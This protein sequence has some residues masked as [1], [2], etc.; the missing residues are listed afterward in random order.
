M[1]CVSF[2]SGRVVGTA[3]KLRQLSCVS[4]VSALLLLS[5]PASSGSFRGRKERHESV[6]SGLT[7]DM[8]RSG[9]SLGLSVSLVSASMRA[10][11]ALA[12]DPSGGSC[13]LKLR[14]ELDGCQER[15]ES[16]SGKACIAQC[17]GHDQQLRGCPTVKCMRAN[18]PHGIESVND[19]LIVQ[20]TDKVTEIAKGA[21]ATGVN[22]PARQN[23]PRRYFSRVRR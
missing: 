2:A 10:V 14:S 15:S 7:R 17:Q 18:Q 12:S 11:T 19:S 8:L 6:D 20:N 9:C 16:V 22:G 1:S 5:R 4:S 23:L 21:E 13:L 3:R